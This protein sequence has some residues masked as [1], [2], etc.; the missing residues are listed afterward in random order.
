MKDKWF[1][2]DV[3]ERDW[4]FWNS[5]EKAKE[6]AEKILAAYRDMAAEDGWPEEEEFVLW[7]QARGWNA[8]CEIEIREEFEERDE[9]WPYNPDFDEV[10][11]MKLVEEEA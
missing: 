6:E 2:Y 1:T 3:P 10:Y 5:E 7:G 9:G 8:R 4:T 11:N